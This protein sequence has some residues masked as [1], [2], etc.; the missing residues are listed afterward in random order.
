MQV[1]VEFDNN[2]ST[3]STVG[4]KEASTAPT[5]TGEIIKTENVRGKPIMAYTMGG[6]EIKHISTAYSVEFLKAYTVR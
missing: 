1:G 4:G 6:G 5:A 3:A 2:I